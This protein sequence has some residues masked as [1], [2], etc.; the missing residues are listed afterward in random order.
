PTATAASF[1]SSLITITTEDWEATPSAARSAAAPTPPRQAAATPAAAASAAP[2]PKAAATPVAAE[3][4]TAAA[5][6]NNISR[7]IMQRIALTPR[8]N[9][10]Q[11]VES[12]GLIFHTLENGTPYWDESAAYQFTSAEIDTLEAA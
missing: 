6:A 10:Q 11:K 1:P 4:A 2:S 5:A 3:A 9:W 8:D 7:R 12:V